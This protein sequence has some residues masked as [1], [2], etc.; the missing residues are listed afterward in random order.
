MW[1][2]F[3][4]KGS[5]NIKNLGFGLN[6]FLG[7]CHDMAKQDVS[8]KKVSQAACGQKFEMKMYI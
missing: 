6:E 2:D 8:Q 4:Y 1:C 7:F 3:E 5:L